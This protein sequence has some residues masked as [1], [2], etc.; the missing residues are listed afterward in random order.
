MIELRF[1][2]ADRM[3]T[4]SCHCIR[5]S[6]GRVLLDC[7]LFQGRRKETWK[8]NSVFPFDAAGID[9]AVLSHAHIDH[10]GRLPLLVRDGFRGAIHATAPTHDLCEVMLLDCAHILEKDAEFLNRRRKKNHLKGEEVEALYCTGDV[11]KTMNRFVAH[12]Y[13]EWFEP[14]AGLRIRFHDA[15]H[16]LGSA[17]VEAE[18]REGERTVR[19][20]FTG[21]HGR[22]GMPILRDPE[23]LCA[24]DVYIS[25]STYGNRLHPDL[26]GMEAELAA[27]VDRLRRRGRGRLLIPAFAVGRTQNLLYSLGRLFRNGAGPPIPVVVDSPM[28]AKATEVVARHREVFDQ[29]ALAELPVGPHGP[30]FCPGVRFTHSVDESKGLN[31]HPG[32]LILLSASGMMESGRILHHLAWGVG[33]EE[34]EILVVGFQAQH[35]LGRRLLEGA[36]EV[37]ILG[38]RHEVRA[39]VTAMLGFSAHA[40]RNDLLAAL[41]P[42]AQEA[43]TLFLVHGEDDQRRPL[44]EEL[45]RRGFARIEEP[46]ERQAFRI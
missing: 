3:T 45:A 39:R 10:S 19:L 9:A 35:T 27:A 28:A 43:E 6:G 26:S 30:E 12:R 13:G 14:A 36:R 8:K 23:P 20:V 44:A 11:E 46:V 17:W 7:G 29:E 4:G 5:F 38:R 37:N 15:G 40:D 21:D 22:K 2:G 31:A 32:P 25:E 1:F 41:A 18:I 42:H 33:R 16:I 34:T 24:A